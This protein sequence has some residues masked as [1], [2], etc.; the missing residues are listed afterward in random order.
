VRLGFRHW[1]KL[2]RGGRTRCGC[3]SRCFYR[4]PGRASSHRRTRRSCHRRVE[5]EHGFVLSP[6]RE[7]RMRTTSSGFFLTKGY[8]GSCWAG[9]WAASMGCCWAPAAR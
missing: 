6:P 8:T 7:E 9:A 2:E 1:R 5:A 4:A 3:S